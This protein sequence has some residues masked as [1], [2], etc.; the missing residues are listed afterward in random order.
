M[1]TP[2]DP[3]SPHLRDETA[4][5]AEQPDVAVGVPSGSA[6]PPVSVPV[7]AHSVVLREG[8][9]AANAG[10]TTGAA[11]TNQPKRRR[12]RNLAETADRLSD[13]DWQILRSV[14][15][16]R[17]LTT[18]QIARLHF[19]DH[20]TASGPTLARRVLGRLRDRRLVA[21]LERRVGGVR[22]GSAGL[23]Y[24]VDVVGDRILR[25]EAERPSRRRFTEPSPTFLRHTLAL[26]DT[27]VS[28]VEAERRNECQLVRLDVEPASWR[29]HL[30]LGGAQ[31]VLKPDLYLET[32]VDAASPY[33]NSWFLEVDLGTEHLPALIRKSRDY[34]AYYRSGT[35]QAGSGS[36]PLVVWM[37]SARDSSTT[38]RRIA[39]LRKAIDDDDRLDGTLFRVVRPEQLMTL[40]RG[41]G[42]R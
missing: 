14:S 18:A 31:L 5:H 16:H 37:M 4:I 41:G 6:S 12:T 1:M 32:A 42:Q 11:A 24:Y 35:E 7:S 19:A 8:T 21:T 28:L 29:K 17:F 13:R 30:G 10:S 34:D 36:F 39:A 22:A 3:T 40:I 20:S 27:H 38:D 33:I 2:A 15:A 25:R 9:D 23:V 26:A